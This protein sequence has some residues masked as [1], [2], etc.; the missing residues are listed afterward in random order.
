MSNGSSETLAYP[1]MERFSR[2][3]SVSIVWLGKGFLAILDQGLIST[4]NFA[5]GVL[6]ARWL[7]PTQYGA[8]ALAFAIFLYF[9]QVYQSL[10]LEPMSVFG[11]S[12]YRQCLPGYLRTLLRMHIIAMLGALIVLGFL[13]WTA[14][15]LGWPDGL[16]GA[17]AAVTVATP[18]ILLF[19]LTRRAFYL[20]LSPAPA[21]TGA[22]LY[23]VL[24]FAGLFLLYLKASLSAST[25]FLLMGL[26][27]FATSALLLF[28]LW[29]RH[30]FQSAIAAPSLRE[31]WRQHWGYGR[32]ALASTIAI[33]IPD[34]IYYPVVASCCGMTH[35]G[36]LKA[37]VNLSMPIFQFAGALSLLFLTYGARVNHKDGPTG[38][39]NFTRAMIGLFVGGAVIYWTFLVSFRLQVVH[40]LYGA[41]YGGI[42]PLVPLMALASVLQVAVAGPG[43]GLRAMGFPAFIFAAYFASCAVAV[44]I[45][46]P[47]TRVYGIRGAV[48][49]MI[50]SYLTALSVEVVLLTRIGRRRI[51][52]A[53]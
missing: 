40:S 43:I 13:A 36:E 16:P 53:T 52:G 34:N 17:L 42:I 9:S 2:W 24:V 45:G 33:W 38:V 49:G 46:I 12:N 48:I 22:L 28:R 39:R 14:R 4:S 23:C 10:L 6:L 26:A 19:W 41:N 44:L 50:F 27:A 7:L 35:A 29:R 15:T 31:T 18:C 25:A 30:N 1:V 32:W 20:E 51:Q 21:A 47:L 37:L 11:G 3:W 8:Y 5:A